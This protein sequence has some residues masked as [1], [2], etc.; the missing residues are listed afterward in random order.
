MSAAEHTV[1]AMQRT[2]V[3]ILHEIAKA[4]MPFP[5]SRAVFEGCFRP[6]YHGWL[7]C[8]GSAGFANQISGFLIVLAQLDE[9]QILN[10]CIKSSARR[11]GLASAMLDEAVAFVKSRGMRKVFLEVRESNQAAIALYSRYGF[12]TVG[13]RRRYY[14]TET[15]TEDALV[16]RM[17]LAG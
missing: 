11:Q 9:C 12:D 16:M 10:V 14:K 1:R 15:G 6:D 2:D 7:A 17:N 3:P 5:W 13:R 8:D 4:N